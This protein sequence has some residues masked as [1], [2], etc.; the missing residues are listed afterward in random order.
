VLKPLEYISLVAPEPV[1]KCGPL[2]RNYVSK[3]V[4]IEKVPAVVVAMPSYC[5]APLL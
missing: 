2:A 5:L 1:L 4:E 3:L